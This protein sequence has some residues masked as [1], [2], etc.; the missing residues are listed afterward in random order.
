L[1]FYIARFI[2]SYLHL[3]VNVKLPKSGSFEP[4]VL[5]EYHEKIFTSIFECGSLPNTWE[6]L[7]QFGYLRVSEDNVKLS[8]YWTKMQS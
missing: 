1:F 5:G 7:V 6:S 4:Y 8:Q 3:Y 2:A